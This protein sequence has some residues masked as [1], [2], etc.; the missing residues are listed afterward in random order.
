MFGASAGAAGMG[1]AAT[2]KTGDVASPYWNPAGLSGV[3]FTEISIMSAA[4]F[5]DTQYSF[6]GFGYPA[7]KSGAGIFGMSVQR[8]SSGY[9]AGTDSFGR[10]TGIFGETQTNVTLTYARKKSERLSYGVNLKVLDQSLAGWSVRGYGLDAGVV[11]E[12]GTQT[13]YGLCL[14]NVP[15][16]Q[17]GPDTAGMNL[18]AGICRDILRRRLNFSGD[19]YL[20]DLQGK[21]FL[22]WAAGFEYFPADA[23]IVRAGINTREITAGFGFKTE[24][25]TFDY[26]LGAH[27]L[28]FTHKFG[29]SIRYG[30]RYEEA[31]KRMARE[32]ELFRQEAEKA[33]EEMTA[34][35]EEIKKATAELKATEWSG[36]KILS[37]V[38]LI[39]EGK[40][41]DAERVLTEINKKDPEN[42]QAKDLLAEVKR[43]LDVKSAL[44]YFAGA[45]EN[46]KKKNYAAALS[47]AQ[48][49]IASDPTHKG[50]R[51]LLFL[52][53][54]R[55]FAAEGRYSDA[56]GE[57]FEL[58]K[59][60]P[61]NRE[62]L[63]L[64]KR[65]QT[66]I[67]ISEEQ[68]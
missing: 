11:Y 61:E 49:A 44:L 65:V 18:K 56:K 23:F 9:A 19:A 48:K 7:G 55:L 59:T 34:R 24:G 51:E 8:L 67:E 52:S 3:Y 40:Y 39:E 21:P 28:D 4:L 41:A 42:A 1:N 50:A 64:I 15:Y 36:A 63:E 17:M 32:K 60:N 27:P 62:G 33:K 25:V 43:K 5:A 20:I 6:I 30:Y 22:R 16:V 37:A 12:D 35:K 45:L 47:G 57:L 38:N 2:A 58:L 29:L 26:A 14:Q 66:L 10:D 31:R 54:A 68:K 53:Q 46:Y 13:S